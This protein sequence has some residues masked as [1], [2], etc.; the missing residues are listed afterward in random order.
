MIPAP[1]CKKCLYQLFAIQRSFSNFGK[2]LVVTTLKHKE[3]KNLDHQLVKKE[4]FQIRVTTFLRGDLK[5]SFLNDCIKR[6]ITEADL[7]RDIMEIYYATMK[8]HPY[9]LEKEIPAIKNFITDRI[10]FD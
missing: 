7:A 2:P 9:M 10:K 4:K 3:Y 6:G 5:N 8:L 1:L